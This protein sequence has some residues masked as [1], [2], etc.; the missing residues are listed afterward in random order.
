MT[1]RTLT[2]APRGRKPVR[3][4]PLDP[5]ERKAELRREEEAIRRQVGTWGLN[6]NPPADAGRS[7]KR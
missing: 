4:L 6:I 3:Y 5:E 2:L 7:E 1:G